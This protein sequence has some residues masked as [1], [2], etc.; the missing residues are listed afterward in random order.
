MSQKPKRK[1]SEAKEY[2]EYNKA[3]A[4]FRKA[5]EVAILAIQKSPQLLLGQST[6]ESDI[7]LPPDVMAELSRLEEIV[8]AKEKTCSSFIQKIY[9]DW[10]E[11]LKTSD[12]SEPGVHSYKSLMEAVMNSS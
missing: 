10:L 11:E 1:L 3:V 5:Q 8:L 4:T 6:E 2:L 12:V 9:D 7:A